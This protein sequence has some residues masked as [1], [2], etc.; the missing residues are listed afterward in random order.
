MTSYNRIGDTSFYQKPLQLPAFTG[1][2]YDPRIPNNMVV[3]SPGGVSTIYNH[4]THGMYGNGD[5]TKDVYGWQGMRNITGPYNN[6]YSMGLDASSNTGTKGNLMYPPSIDTNFRPPYMSQ[7]ESLNVNNNNQN[8]DL[9]EIGQTIIS[10]GTQDNFKEG[11]EMIDEKDSIQE[12]KEHVKEIVSSIRVKINPIVLFVL[13]VVGSIVFG[14]WY[15]SI[16]LFIKERFHGGTDL[17]LKQITLWALIFS[18]LFVLLMH[19]FGVTLI[20]IE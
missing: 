14:L 4:Y 12:E 10:Q 17:T 13:L 3:A 9:A 19:L 7:A 18:A 1:I 6:M 16:N 8:I 5:L 2:E 15:D 20:N 11:F